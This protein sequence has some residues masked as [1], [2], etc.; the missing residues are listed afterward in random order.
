MVQI[1]IQ[2]LCFQGFLSKMLYFIYLAYFAKILMRSLELNKTF[3]QRIRG[4]QDEDENDAISASSSN[5]TSEI[6]TGFTVLQLHG[7][8][9]SSSV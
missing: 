2:E 4:R 1:E 7:N 9:L 6:L 3:R 8:F 5:S